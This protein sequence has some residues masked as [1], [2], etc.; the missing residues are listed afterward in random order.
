MYM[1]KVTLLLINFRLCFS[2]EMLLMWRHWRDMLTSDVYMS[3]LQAL[4]IDE[5][6]SVENRK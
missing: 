4:S 6:H 1:L 2:P 5:A 3:L